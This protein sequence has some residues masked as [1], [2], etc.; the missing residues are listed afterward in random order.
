MIGLVSASF[1]VVGAS[2]RTLAYGA[3]AAFDH[4][5]HFE[6]MFILIPCLALA[7]HGARDRFH[8]LARGRTWPQAVARGAAIAALAALAYRSY[9]A[10]ERSCRATY[11]DLPRARTFV[12]TLLR[13]V[14]TLRKSGRPLVLLD[15]EFPRYLDWMDMELKWYSQLLPAMGE[16]VKFGSRDAAT[17]RVDEDGHLVRR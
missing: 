5:Y 1:V 11:A 16:P 14:R 17:H 12:T 9:G 2:T 13:D 10:A 15:G 3:L 8:A 6:V 4:R 7:I